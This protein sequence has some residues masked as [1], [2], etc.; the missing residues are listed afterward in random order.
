MKNII[1]TVAD[2]YKAGKITIRQAA[3]RF[4]V[5]GFD[6]YVDERA[7]RARINAVLLSNKNNKT[8]KTYKILWL[9]TTNTTK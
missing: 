9:N 2:D 1:Q 8:N 6:N 3:E 7:T 5:A 4:H